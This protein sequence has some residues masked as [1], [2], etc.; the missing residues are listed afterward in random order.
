MAT[1][2]NSCVECSPA[3]NSSCKEVFEFI[4]L[5]GEHSK[6]PHAIT[7]IEEPL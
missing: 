4:P 2:Q 5:V 1:L 7:Y 3:Q 6:Q